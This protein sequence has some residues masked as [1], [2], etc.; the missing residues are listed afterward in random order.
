M[1]QQNFTCHTATINGV[2]HPVK[3]AQESGFTATRW[4]N[5]GD[6]FIFIN[7]QVNTF[8][9]FEFTIVNMYILRTQLD[10]ARLVFFLIFSLGLEL[11]II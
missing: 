7:V 6:H 9:R 11:R 4:T 10:I 3:S 8:D 2:V 1:I 5:K